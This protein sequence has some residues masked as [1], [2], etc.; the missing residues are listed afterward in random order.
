MDQKKI[1]HKIAMNKYYNNN[2]DKFKENYNN[3][4][5][6]LKEIS[7]TNYNKKYNEDNDFK[8]KRKAYMR[9]YAKKAYKEKKLN[10]NKQ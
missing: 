7:L 1:N 2:K 6:V 10:I 5:E 3:N 8:E 9:E 4:K